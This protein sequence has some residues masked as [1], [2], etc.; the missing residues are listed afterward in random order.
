MKK[1]SMEIFRLFTSVYWKFQLG[2]RKIEWKN[3][4]FLEE[5]IQNRTESERKFEKTPKFY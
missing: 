5:E 3:V 1:L 4:Q 2:I